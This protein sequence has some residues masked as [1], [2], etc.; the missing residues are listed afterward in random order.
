MTPKRTPKSA[1]RATAQ[2]SGLPL[3][4]LFLAAIA[5]IGAI[6]IAISVSGGDDDSGSGG[7]DQTRPVTVE[8]ESLAPFTDDSGNDPA[9]G[10]VAPTITG[11]DFAGRPVTIAADGKPKAVAFVAH[12]CPHCQ[13]EVPRIKRWLDQTGLPADVGLYF[14]STSVNANNPNYPPS[15]W[16]EREGVSDIPT[17][18]DDEA[19]TALQAYGAG[20]FPYLVYLDADNKVV[21]RTSGEYPDDPNVY[22][23][24]FDAL[25]NGE[26]PSDP[27]L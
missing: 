2:R 13:A 14:V 25:A 23:Q 24:V 12:W 22:T 6:A 16:L 27:R 7:V 5:A 15:E 3:F 1:R 19:S 20:G 21:L 26:Q 10:Q 4:P 8:G 18:A 11:E 9:L 17:I